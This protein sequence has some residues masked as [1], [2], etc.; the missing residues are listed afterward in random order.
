MQPKQFQGKSY[1]GWFTVA[2]PAVTEGRNLESVQ[3]AGDDS[4]TLN[5]GHHG[6]FNV[7]KL[8]LADAT[9]S[10]TSI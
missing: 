8:M 7:H 3:S 9:P 2:F 6:I 4:Q 1:A 5:E 10:L